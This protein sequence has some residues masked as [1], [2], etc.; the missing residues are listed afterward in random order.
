MVDQS[1]VY[2]L[3]KNRFVSVD[4]GSG[5]IHTEAEI[6]LLPDGTM[7]LHDIRQTPLKSDT[8]KERGE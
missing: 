8:E 2:K 5:E 7:Y 4:H 3:G 6:E 1:C